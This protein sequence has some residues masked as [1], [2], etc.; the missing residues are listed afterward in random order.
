MVWIY[1]SEIK[2]LISIYLVKLVKYKV[3]VINIFGTLSVRVDVL[4]FVMVR[5]ENKAEKH[6]LKRY[7]NV[8]RSNSA[9]VLL[10]S[11]YTNKAVPTNFGLGTS[12]KSYLYHD[13]RKISDNI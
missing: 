1:L 5:E 3:S 6:W 13:Q 4:F 11:Y 7:A 2:I 12:A 9:V 10:T 8:L